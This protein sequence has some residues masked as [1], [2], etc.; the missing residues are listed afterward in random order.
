MLSSISMT[1]PDDEHL[2]RI[3]EGGHNDNSDVLK[4][5][6]QIRHMN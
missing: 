2:F 6:I 3:L 4:E 1:M 5:H